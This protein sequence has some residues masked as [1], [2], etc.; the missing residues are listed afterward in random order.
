[1][2]TGA[3]VSS[4]SLR[5]EIWQREVYAAAAKEMYFSRFIDWANVKTLGMRT[6]TSPD[7]I[8]QVITDLSK[9][10]GSKVHFGYGDKLSGNGVT[11]DNELEG[12]EEKITYYEDQVL[13]D[14]LRNAVRLQGNMDEKISA[15]N[16]RKDAKNKLAMWLAE[17]M[18]KVVFIHLCGD[19]AGAGSGNSGLYTFANT[20]TA[21]AAT[22]NVWAGG[23]SADG[24][25]TSA[26][27]MDTKVISKAKQTA[28]LASPKVR[29]IKVDG[30]SM[31]VM[32]MHP[33]QTADL[34]VDPVW[35]QAQ[36]DAWWRGSENP[37]FSGALGVYDGVVIHE[38][39]DIWLDEDG[40]SGSCSIARAVLCGAQA[41]V[42]AIGDGP[43]AQWSEKTFDYGNRYG[44]AVG[45]IFGVVTP[46]F[47][48]KQYGV[49]V[50]TTAAAALSTA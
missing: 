50:A 20:P 34:R 3:T 18:Q 7:G 43:G 48:S 13:I 10:R 25:V 38:H 29:P 4:S 24:N 35:N 26:M 19:N 2:A 33:Y 11:G 9:D 8:I 27:K 32:I 39:E 21:P 44:I 45:R 47:N 28:I 15:V 1:M 42:V 5:P 22:R 31:Y 6:E 17:T 40:G 23:V 14:Q 12:N 36:R 37:I 30:K 41:A 49:I 16:M 46:I